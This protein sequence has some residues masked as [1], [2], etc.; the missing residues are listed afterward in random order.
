MAQSFSSPRSLVVHDGELADVCALMAQLGAD[1]TDHRGRPLAEF[2]QIDWDLVVATPMRL[3][4]LDL[5]PGSRP[6]RIAIL[7]WDSKTLC[8]MLQRAAIELIVRRPVHP[9]ALRLL[10]VH[11]L[12]RGPE[13]RQARRVSIGA[14]V[15]IRTGLRR[16]P[17]IL[18]DL[19]VSGCRL[20][21]DEWI[22]AGT[23]VSISIPAEI[24]CGKRLTL[25]GRVVHNDR[26][27]AGTAVSVEFPALSAKLAE[28]LK[29]TISAHTAGPAVCEGAAAGVCAETAAP[30]PSEP[31]AVA[32]GA[33]DEP[34]LAPTADPGFSVNRDERRSSPRRDFPKQVVAQGLGVTR[35][36]IGRDIS[37]GG[38]RVEPHAEVCLGDDLEIAVHL[39]AHGEPLII[40]ARIERDDGEDGLLLMFHDLSESAASCLRRMLNFLPIIEVRNEGAEGA[41]IMVSEILEVKSD[42]A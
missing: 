25:S 35:V 10:I 31:A 6:T 19:S 11:F 17:A 21:C 14:S 12:Y 39:R 2:A 40:Q 28:R 23:R 26:S 42:G 4:E 33:D 9:E 27:A 29:G 5:A 16:R 24:A 18:T 30:R 34:T 7:Q 20:R 41:G 32:V 13:K 36:L 3:L 38:M 1:H 22:P 15:R 8:S 37:L